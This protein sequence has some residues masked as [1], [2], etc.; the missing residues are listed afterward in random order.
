[1]RL[2]G[3]HLEAEALGGA[4]AGVGVDVGL[5]S[6]ALW[7]WVEL[8]PSLGCTGPSDSS[9]AFPGPRGEH[10]AQVTAEIWGGQWLPKPSATIFLCIDTPDPHSH[11][12]GSSLSRA[13]CRWGSEASEG[14]GL[15]Q[16]PQLG[17]GAAGSASGS[18]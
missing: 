3:S 4:G 13:F 16:S 1:M 11:L 7:P 9:H 15:G 5:G 6:R 8:A 14:A 18:A 2:S 10:S 12:A 17:T